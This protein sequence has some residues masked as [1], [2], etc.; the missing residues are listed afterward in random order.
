MN[1]NII[2]ALVGE[3][4]DSSK[5]STETKNLMKKHQDLKKKQKNTREKI[6]AAELNKLISKKQP[7]DIRNYHTST[8]QQVLQQGKGFKMMKKKLNTRRLQF[9]GVLE[10][11]RTITTDRGRIVNRAK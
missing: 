5:L 1:N 10:A 9:T 4:E 2:K 8:I 6:E 3:A 11:D 7:R